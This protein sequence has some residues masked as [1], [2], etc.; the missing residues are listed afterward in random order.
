MDRD[1]CDGRSFDSSGGAFPNGYGVWKV[2]DDRPPELRANYCAPGY[3][4]GDGPGGYKAKYRGELVKHPCERCDDE[5]S[6]NK[7]S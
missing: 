1:E 6:T 3:R 2:F 5:P 7:K 4:P